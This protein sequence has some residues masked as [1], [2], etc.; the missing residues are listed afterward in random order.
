MIFNIFLG[1]LI[2]RLNFIRI[3]VNKYLFFKEFQ[4]REE[5]IYV[6]TF[7]KSGTT[8]MQM[9]LYQM[10][11]D[12][13]MYFNHIYDV[14]PWLSNEAISSTAK[15]VNSLPSPRIIKSHDCYDDF[16]SAMKGRII[17]VYRDGRDVLV[18]LNAHRR[19]YNNPEE[20]MDETFRNFFLMDVDIN[21]FRF[22]EEWLS[23]KYNLPILYV[24][25]SDL[26]NDFTETIKRIA[27]FLNISIDTID[28]ERIQKRS[29]FEYMKKY[30]NKFGEQPDNKVVYNQFIRKGKE[31]EGEAVL[32]EEQKEY[33]SLNYKKYLE[34]YLKKIR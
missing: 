28:M 18:S 33:I 17:Y 14:S 25:Y 1:Q 13:N 16:D 26:K 31:G 7:V 6:V 11:T 2:K 3:H 30:E 10:L 9:I 34:H 23:N 19:S 12:G 4:Q 29:S 22:N 5:D 8:W 32:S 20:T 21:W 15:R 27:G 24:K